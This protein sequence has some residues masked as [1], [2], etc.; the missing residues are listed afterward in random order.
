LRGASSLL[1]AVKRNLPPVPTSSRGLGC[2]APPKN[3]ISKN[4][5]LKIDF[6]YLIHMLPW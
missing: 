1:S 4:R 3:R 6:A 2:M 5:F